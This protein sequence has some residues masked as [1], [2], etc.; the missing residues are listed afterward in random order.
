MS[1]RDVL[2]SRI[3]DREDGPADWARFEELVRRDE[4]ATTGLIEALRDEATLRTAVGEVVAVA[5][6]VNIRPREFARV[7]GLT[8]WGGWMAA[9][10]LALIWIATDPRMKRGPEDAPRE[11]AVRSTEPD[12][13]Q[14]VRLAGE[15]VREL[16]NV[17]VESRAIPGSDQ[18]EVVY[19]RR[20]LERAVVSDAYTVARDETG[21][22]FKTRADLTRFAPK[23]SY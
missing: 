20:V 21:Q 2:I 5:D 7:R 18:V 1:D 3:V 14:P 13:S 11:Q 4:R 17:M 8:H 16:P 19:L 6:R 15:V 22:P 10:I 23:R 12:A 9:A